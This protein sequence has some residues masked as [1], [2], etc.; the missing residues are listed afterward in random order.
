M[1]ND[2]TGETRR[3]PLRVPPR[4]SRTRTSRALHPSH[5]SS[6]PKEKDSTSPHTKTPPNIRRETVRP[7]EDRLPPP[8]L[9]PRHIPHPTPGQRESPAFSSR[10]CHS[11][12]APTPGRRPNL[13]VEHTVTVPR[14]LPG[15]CQRTRPCWCSGGDG[16][17]RGAVRALVRREASP[18]RR[19]ERPT[20]PPAPS[21]PPLPPPSRPIP[22][23]PP[24]PHPPPP[25]P[26]LPAA[27]L[28]GSL[29]PPRRHRKQ[30]R[31]PRIAAVINE[32]S[33]EPP[34]SPN[35]VPS[36]HEKRSP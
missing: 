20:P 18:E 27:K 33:D 12:E 23:H 8:R 30:N 16:R 28:L 7:S 5:P 17:E 36:S 1:T 31:L 3:G 14:S 32:E 21:S 6:A 26:P 11:Q 29:P 15:R 25:P 4:S 19:E 35:P 10:R 34:P 9:L 22:P 24:P 2:Q 13:P